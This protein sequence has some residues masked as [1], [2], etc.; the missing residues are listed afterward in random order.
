[1]RRSELRERALPSHDGPYPNESQFGR[2]QSPCGRL[3]SCSNSAHA[4]ARSD[5]R[6]KSSVRRRTGSLMFR[7]LPYVIRLEDDGRQQ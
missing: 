6:A 2:R 3:R 5:A 4:G 1:M 7:V